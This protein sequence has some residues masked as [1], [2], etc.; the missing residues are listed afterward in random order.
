MIDIDRPRIDWL[1]MAKSMGVPA[2]AVDTAEASTRRWSTRPASRARLI[3]VRLVV[4]S[5]QEMNIHATTTTTG[6]DA[7]HQPG[8]LRGHQGDEGRARQV[9]PR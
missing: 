8:R 5:H 6:A 9:R 7:A 4:S 1:A 3:E 2:V